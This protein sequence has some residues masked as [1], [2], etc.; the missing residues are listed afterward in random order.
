MVQSRN[1]NPPPT[2][3]TPKKAPWDAV[4]DLTS[5]LDRLISLQEASLGLPGAMITVAP[6]IAVAV[7]R[8][9]QLI[10]LL[11]SLAPESLGPSRVI[12]FQKEVATAYQDEQN[13]SIMSDGIIRDVVMAFPAGCQQLVE[14]RLIYSPKGGSRQFIIP[15]LEEAFIALDDFTQVFQPHY[16]IKG[17]GVMTVE[18]WNYDSQNVHNVPV[19][20]VIAPTGLEVS[21]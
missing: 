20:V 14:V 8:Q 2:P 15:T 11:Q 21:T 10:P 6:E 17:P 18:W 12:P 4:E 3:S 7:S 9:T 1:I 16:P 13:R 5:R 19:T